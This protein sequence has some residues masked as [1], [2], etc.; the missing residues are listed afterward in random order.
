[1]REDVPDDTPLDQ[2]RPTS[3]TRSGSRSRAHS[4]TSRC[5]SVRSKKSWQPRRE[6]DRG[7]Q[8]ISGTDVKPDRV[9]GLLARR[10]LDGIVP[11]D[12]RN[13]ER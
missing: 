3:S 1:M 10:G 11:R 9:V 2:P 13:A 4:I 12:D 7:H 6:E 8:S 5:R